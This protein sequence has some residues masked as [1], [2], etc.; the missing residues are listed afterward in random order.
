MGAAV[1]AVFTTLQYVDLDQYV[2]GARN[3]K[4][5]RVKENAIFNMITSMMFG[6]GII[7]FESI[8]YCFRKSARVEKILRICVSLTVSVQRFI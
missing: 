8:N 7:I 2:E 6:V 4:Y 5:D 3:E 1:V